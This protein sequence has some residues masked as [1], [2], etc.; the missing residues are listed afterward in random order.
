MNDILTKIQNLR[1]ESANNRQSRVAARAGQN[2]PRVSN[3]PQGSGGGA[4]APP[5]ANPKGGK[6]PKAKPNVAS[7]R[8]VGGGAVGG[9]LR[10]LAK[11]LKL[12]DAIKNIHAS[13][14]YA[15]KHEHPYD[16]EPHEMP[17]AYG[18]PAKL[19]SAIT[20]EHLE[21]V[22]TPYGPG[23]KM[24]GREFLSV[25]TTGPQTMSAGSSILALP[26]NPRVLALPRLSIMSKL[27]TRFIFNKFCLNYCKSAG[28]QN[29]G[30][31]QIFGVYDPTVDPTV[32]P[33][34]TLIAYAAQRGATDLSLYQD[35][36]LTMDDSHFKDLLFLEPD[37][38]LRW[39][40]QGVVFVIASGAIAAN[41]E[42]GKIMLD[43]E[44]TFCN[45]DLEDDQVLAQRN[46]RNITATIAITS[47][48]GRSEWSIS[49]SPPSGKYY[50]AVRTNPT[51]GV[52]A[53]RDVD[54]SNLANSAQLYTIAAGF[55][56]YGVVVGGVLRLLYAPDLYDE[57]STAANYTKLMVNGAAIT[58]GTTMVVDLYKYTEQ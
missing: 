18:Q 3:A 1:I 46:F 50:V 4:Q 32:R 30:S 34:E 20:E 33:G 57:D 53:Y 25:I 8:P 19:T 37:D 17:V 11:K 31:L 55:G 49:G 48:G 15:E 43:Y 39:T 24:R 21:P 12:S 13:N 36:Y 6:Q 9:P 26:L 23:V 27:Y 35:A 58:P 54:A 2:A 28:T 51:N 7:S 52:T 44:V 16:R 29:N 42:C 38:D 45:D 5:Q 22:Q 10:S 41:L 14:S 40:M 56:C 47:A